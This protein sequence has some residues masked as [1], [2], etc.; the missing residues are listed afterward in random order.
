MVVG[1]GEGWLTELSTDTLREVFTL[2][3]EALDDP[4]LDEE[5]DDA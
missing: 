2:G 4:A 5:A 1:E 3:A